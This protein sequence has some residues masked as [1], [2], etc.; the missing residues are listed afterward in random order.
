MPSRELLC[1]LL[2]MAGSSPF[3]ARA[4]DSGPFAFG[5]F[6]RVERYHL[7]V[8]AE[9][10][11]GSRRLRLSELAPHLSRG[12]RR[13]VLPAE[14]YG[15]GQEQVQLLRQALPALARL[16]CQLEPSASRVSLR[17]F[18]APVG[19]DELRRRGRPPAPGM[20]HDDLSASCHAP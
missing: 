3:V 11:T 16:V 7:E 5:M 19:A 14:G 15:F 8:R 12:A 10:A 18:H 2:V 13:V 6:T 4:L 9:L 20:P 17:L 1:V